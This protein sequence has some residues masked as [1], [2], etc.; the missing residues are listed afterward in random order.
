VLGQYS[1]YLQNSLVPSVPGACILDKNVNRTSF[2]VRKK[3]WG[4]KPECGICRE[5]P[6]KRCV[7][8]VA[9]W[10]HSEHSVKYLSRHAHF[11][12]ERLWVGD[13]CAWPLEELSSVQN[14]SILCSHKQHVRLVAEAVHVFVE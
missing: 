14:V 10:E 9:P 3:V 8:H 5:G 1:L 6:D 13:S 4:T 2:I 12:Q 11:S 7:I